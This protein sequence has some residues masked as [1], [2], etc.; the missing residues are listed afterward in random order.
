MKSL[1]FILYIWSDIDMSALNKEDLKKQIY[2]RLDQNDADDIRNLGLNAPAGFRQA[3]DE[4]FESGLADKNLFV[5]NKAAL[6]NF[7]IP[8]L[9]AFPRLFEQ[10]ERSQ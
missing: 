9:I 3:L 6:D 1:K 5:V 2:E 7:L 8:S 4:F 10:I